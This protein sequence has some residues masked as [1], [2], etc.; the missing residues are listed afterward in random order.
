MEE[1]YA[2]APFGERPP[3][4]EPRL[5]RLLYSRR[6]VYLAL[7]LAV[8]LVV[9]L[10]GWWVLEGR[11][12]SVPSVGGMTA[13]AARADL[14][15]AGLTVATGTSQ[16]DNHVAKGHVIRT[17]PADGAR[18]SRG[19]QVT[20]VVS[21]GPRMISMP[22]VTGQPLGA[23]EDAL[24]HAGLVP[25][26]VRRQTSATI[27]AGIVLATRPVA[28]TAWPQ[29][30][31][32]ALVVSSGPPLPNFVGQQKSAAEAWAGANN[33]QLNEVAA[34][35]SEAP[36]GTVLRQ[37]LPPGHAFTPHQVITIVYSPGPP[38]VNVPNV[39]GMRVGQA[40]NVL[41]KLGFKVTV[42]GFKMFQTVVSYSPQG[43]APKGTTITLEVGIQF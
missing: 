9:G 32:V 17:I 14:S 35:R 36:A 10:L 30:E 12:T 24:R 3:P 13:A 15:D 4:R 33:V 22:E 40:V 27:A 18:I 28:G 16:T 43:A 38:M 11:Y 42:N 2:E 34:H 29:P 19:G 41:T 8:V 20:L 6:L 39:D 26:R 23:A 1:P 7:A 5:Q 31:P 25:G 37:S 21:A